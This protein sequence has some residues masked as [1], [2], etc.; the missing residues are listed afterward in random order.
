MHRDLKPS[1]ILL[2]AVGP[3]V[4]DFGIARIVEPDATQSA[5]ISGTPAYMAPEQANGGILTSAGDIFAWG[6]VV[7]YAGIG[8][9][10]FGTGPI[11]Q[12]LLR[13]A[14]HE[15]VLDGLDERLR[16]LVARA[17]RKDPADRPSA[18]QL[19]DHL[20]GRERATTIA[21]TRAVSDAWTPLVA[22]DEPP[23]SPPRPPRRWV[24]PAIATAVAVAITAGVWTAV[25]RP[26]QQSPATA[27]PATTTTAIAT[28]T[29]TGPAVAS[30]PDATGAGTPGTQK[31]G[32]LFIH[33][34]ARGEQVRGH[35]Q[36]DS[37]AWQGDNVMLRYTVRNDDAQATINL[38]HL[39]E[40][41][42]M[43]TDGIELILPDQPFPFTPM[44]EDGRCACSVWP[45]DAFLYA[46][47][48]TRGYAAFRRV[49]RSAKI[50]D[51][52]LKDVGLFKNVVITR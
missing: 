10:P 36:I 3:R 32:R 14:H 13:I 39:I 29:I 12:V 21:A 8:R 19:L 16:P 46:G 41:G 22:P 20:L 45:P 4:I 35:L 31:T 52:D 33:T 50:V 47:K 44:I 17:L 5:V 11:P 38:Y 25:F 18:Q 1:N 34:N 7:T 9:P 27:S 37:L 49:P 40:Q 43:T 6:C 15:P 28:T 42:G 51:L 30:T 26:W 24:R 2:S 23:P 48:S